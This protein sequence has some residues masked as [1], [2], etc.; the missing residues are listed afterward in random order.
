METPGSLFKNPIPQDLPKEVSKCALCTCLSGV[1]CD[2]CIKQHLAKG[3]YTGKLLVGEHPQG[4]RREADDS[5]H[6][7]I[8]GL[9]KKGAGA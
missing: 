3:W 1:N 4:K 5:T 8:L 2:N 6:P 9:G 7:C